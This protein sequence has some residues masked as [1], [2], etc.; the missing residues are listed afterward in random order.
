MTAP[1]EPG[2]YALLI[3]GTTVEIRPARPDD[4][5]AVR[6]MHAQMAPENLHLGRV[7]GSGL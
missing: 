2:T 6:D 7:R 5:E 4:F 3:D 1:A